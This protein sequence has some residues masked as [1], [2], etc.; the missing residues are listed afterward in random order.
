MI[1]SKSCN[2]IHDIYQVVMDRVKNKVVHNTY[3]LNF[4]K[5]T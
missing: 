5:Q 3:V 4:N 2:T 1:L